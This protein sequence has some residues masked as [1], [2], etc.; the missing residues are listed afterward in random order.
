MHPIA[1]RKK[2]EVKE[3]MDDVDDLTQMLIDEHRDDAHKYA[4]KL[5]NLPGSFGRNDA[6]EHH[7]LYDAYYALVCHYTLQRTVDAVNH[8]TNLD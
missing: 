4:T 1:P 5:L 2:R 6:D 7:S 3:E 8:L